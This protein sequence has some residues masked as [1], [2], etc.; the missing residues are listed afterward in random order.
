MWTKYLWAIF[1]FL[2]SI[3][4][5]ISSTTLNGASVKPCNDMMK[6]I[7]DTALSPPDCDWWSKILRSEFSLN[8]TK[9]CSL[10]FLNRSSLTNST[11]PSLATVVKRFWNDLEILLTALNNLVSQF[12]CTAAILLSKSDFLCS[13]LGRFLSELLISSNFFLKLSIDVLSATDMTDLSSSKSWIFDRIWNSVN[14][15]LLR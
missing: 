9:I 3:P 10:Q 8:L 4:W 14:T 6:K 7:V 1:S 11:C 15:F 2:G 13:N 12:C 5:L